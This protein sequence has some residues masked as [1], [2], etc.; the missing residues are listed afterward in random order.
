MS[1]RDREREATVFAIRFPRLFP[2]R[3]HHSFIVPKVF[4]E[5]LKEGL[6]ASLA[7]VEKGSFVT[8]RRREIA[9]SLFNIS[10][11][12]KPVTASLAPA[13]CTQIFCTS[14]YR[15]PL[16]RD[17]SVHHAHVP[18]PSIG[19]GQALSAAAVRRPRGA[20][21]ATIV[22]F[23]PMVSRHPGLAARGGGPLNLA[24]GGGGGTGRRASSVNSIF[25]RS[26]APSRLLEQYE[27]LAQI[28]EGSYGKV[29]K[30][31]AR[32]TGALVA[33]KKFQGSRKNHPQ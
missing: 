13:A 18:T 28:G 25:Y 2:A 10:S 12:R 22:F 7:C 6:V 3:A 8:A 15:S 23:S 9:T 21:T 11:C 30:C 24:N 26:R 32:D 1:G 16:P 14:R 5:G 27:K 20:R 17:P 31:R 29:Y 4:L 19:L 33:I